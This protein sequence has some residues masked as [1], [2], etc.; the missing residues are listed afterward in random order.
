MSEVY[1][2]PLTDQEQRYHLAEVLSQ[3]KTRFY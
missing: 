1:Y 3:R 2:T